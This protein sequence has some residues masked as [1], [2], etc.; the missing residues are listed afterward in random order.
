MIDIENIIYTE[1]VDVLKKA[2]PDVFVTSEIIQ[3]PPKFPCVFIN[4]IGNITDINTGTTSEIENHSIITYEIQV[5]SDKDKGKKTE[6]KKIL[7]VLDDK[8]GKLGFNRFMY[9]SIPNVLDNSIYRVLARYRAEVGK[10]FTI[11]RRV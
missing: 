2:Y 11:Y 9:S 5:F 10:N 7:Q 1:L 6:C 8:M 3:S 4:E